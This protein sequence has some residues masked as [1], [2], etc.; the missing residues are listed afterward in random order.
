MALWREKKEERK[1]EA[2]KQ[3]LSYNEYRTVKG[4]DFHIRALPSD[5]QHSFNFFCRYQILGFSL[6][7]TTFPERGKK[8]ALQI[9]KIQ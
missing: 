4:S 6:S 1:K 8:V 7:L 3:A 9:L 5:K 2:R